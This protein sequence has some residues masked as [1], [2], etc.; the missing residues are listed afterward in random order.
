MFDRELE[1]P[2]AQSVESTMTCDCL[3]R[4]VDSRPTLVV[5]VAFLTFS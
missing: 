3:V 2:L 1:L 4:D 5:T